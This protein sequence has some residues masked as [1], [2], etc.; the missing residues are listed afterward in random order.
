MKFIK[1]TK[2]KNPRFRYVAK[3]TPIVTQKKKKQRK[4][5]QKKKTMEEN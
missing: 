2:K 4:K 3:L 1:Q 5:T